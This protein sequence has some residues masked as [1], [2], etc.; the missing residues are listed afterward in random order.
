VRTH[1]RQLRTLTA[2]SLSRTGSLSR[3]AG[4]RAAVAGTTFCDGCAQVCTA[5]CRSAAR[6]EG[7]RTR[8]LA[9]APIR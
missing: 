7:A 6:V 8:A 3:A 5:D 9:M 2:G 4:R 1:P